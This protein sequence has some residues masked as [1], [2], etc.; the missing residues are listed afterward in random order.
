[1]LNCLKIAFQ[2]DRKKLTK[3]KTFTVKFRVVTNTKTKYINS[4]KL[5]VP[6]RQSNLGI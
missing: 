3:C 2:I 6:S 1:M 5:D 4:V